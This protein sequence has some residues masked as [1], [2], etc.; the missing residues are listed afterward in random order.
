MP[1]SVAPL[2]CVPQVSQTYHK[3]W[4]NSIYLLNTNHFKSQNNNYFNSLKMSTFHQK[5]LSNEI[6]NHALSREGTQGPHLHVPKS[7]AHLIC[8][9]QVPQMWHKMWHNFIHFWFFQGGDGVTPQCPLIT[10]IMRGKWGVKSSTLDLPNFSNQ[11]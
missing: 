5:W 3:M 4:H 9:P 1:Q 10:L 11:I 8:V 6:T 2:I 7:V